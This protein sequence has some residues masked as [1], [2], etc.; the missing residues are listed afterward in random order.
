MVRSSVD[1]GVAAFVRG[2]DGT[3]AKVPDKVIDGLKA[4][5]MNGL[6][7]L[8]EPPRLRPGDPVKVTGGLLVGALGIYT[9]MRGADRVAVL[10]GAL[11]VA[12]MPMSATSPA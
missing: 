2:A 9:G 12:V 3:P 5:E 6:V 4:S 11:G 7:Q 1:P 10:L 8:P